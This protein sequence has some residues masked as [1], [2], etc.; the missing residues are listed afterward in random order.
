MSVFDK[1][2]SKSPVVIQELGMSIF[3]LR[4]EIKRSG[5]TFKKDLDFL[6]KSYYWDKE[7][8][9]EYQLKQLR[10]LLM[11]VKENSLYY[12]SILSK[13]DVTSFTLSDMKDIP[14]LTKSSLRAQF[15]EILTSH[16]NVNMFYTSG[17]SG[18]PLKIGLSNREWATENAFIWRQRKL[19]GISRFDRIATFGGRNIVAV[20]E[21]KKF[22]RRNFT[23]NQLLFSAYHMMDENMYIYIDKYNRWKP[24]YIQG[25][26]S[27]IHIIAKYAMN[28]NILLN[29][30]KAIFTSSETLLNY[31]KRDIES[32][33]GT[34]IYDF[35]GS[36]ERAGIITQCSEGNYHVNV[37]SGFLEIIDSKFYWTSF[38]NKTTPIIRYDIGD[39]GKY[40]ISTDGC[41]CG[42]NFPIISDL[43]GRVEDYVFTKDLRPLGRLDHIFKNDMNIKEAQIVQEKIGEVFIRIVPDM[44]FNLEEVKSKIDNAFTERVG[45][46]LEVKIEVCDYINKTKNG[47]FKFVIS[48]VRK[49]V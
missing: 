29:K 39:T 41:K 14:I 45:N 7:T 4:R 18:T 6:M 11:W 1:L 37:E 3:A 27:S 16:K 31:Q 28:N 21:M 40:G 47:K 19:A 22:W 38:I 48:N 35:Y 2:Y 17:T 20:D 26:P 36:T 8:I 25:Y 44:N 34:K 46:S 24:D 9:E 23:N 32:A 12:K 30:P 5:K 15:D 49:E 13:L 33:F 43:S 42:S 10:E